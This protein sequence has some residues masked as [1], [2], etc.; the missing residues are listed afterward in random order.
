MK[1]GFYSHEKS[2]F[3]FRKARGNEE[4]LTKSENF[5]GGLQKFF[6]FI[7]NVEYWT[8]VKS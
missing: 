8:C 6:K 1:V 7:E 2:N 3:G 5:F 4:I